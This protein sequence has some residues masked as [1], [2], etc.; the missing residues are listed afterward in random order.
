MTYRHNY[1]LW[2]VTKYGESNR[3]ANT[4]LKDMGED[5]DGMVESTSKLQNLIKGMTGF[6]IM[7][8]DGKT[9]KDIYDIVLGIGEKWQD[10]NDVD[11]ASLLEKL[12]SKNQSNALASALNNIDILKKS[13]NEATN[14]EGSA[15]KEQAE[16]QKSV[17]YS[18]DQTK[19]KLEELANDALSSDFLKGAIDNAGKLISA[20]DA[21]I[22][23][24]RL[25]PNIFAAIGTALSIK[26]IGK[27]CVS[28]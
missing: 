2:S 7:K 20:L 19:A 5:T 28:A 22:K 6:D 24:G 12:A 13:Y 16:F 8:S 11:R 10:L 17:Q 14:A 1:Y 9:F 18:I 27:C 3:M 25:I 26:N 4:E 23:D 15:E 21:V